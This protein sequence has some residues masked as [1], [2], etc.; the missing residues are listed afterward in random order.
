[1]A[2]VRRYGVLPGR[3]AVLLTNNDGAY[4]TALDLAASGASIAAII[5]LRREAEGPLPE[6]V[7]QRSIEIL[8]GHAIVATTGKFRVDAVTAMPLTEAG[9][10]GTTRV[11]PCDLV[12]N[13]GGFTPSVHLFSQS[14]GKLAW[15]ESIGA[16]LPGTS[17][18][19]ERSAGACRGSFSLTDCVAEGHAAG[20]AAA[21]AAGYVSGIGAPPP[22][23]PPAV[24]DG[25]LPARKLW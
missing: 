24:A 23:T 16:F 3:R 15:N 11:I 4:R 22:W 6:Q 13:S 9:V 7:R 14:R 20:I 8:T 21:A 17:V 19:A 2:Y 1:S 5:D 10:G 25:P 18:Q 12:L